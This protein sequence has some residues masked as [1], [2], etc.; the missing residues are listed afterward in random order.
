MFA[1]TPVGLP[2]DLVRR[3]RADVGADDPAGVNPTHTAS[4]S[5]SSGLAEAGP[6]FEVSCTGHE[7][8]FAEIAYWRPLSTLI[9]FAVLR[10]P[11]RTERTAER[12]AECPSPYVYVHSSSLHGTGWLETAD[13]VQRLWNP[14][15]LAVFD[16]TRQG[17]YTAL[18]IS[19]PVG[20]CIPADLLG[21]PD[22]P[23]MASRCTTILDD[24]LA[25]AVAAFVRNFACDAAVRRMDVQVEDELVV[26]D[27]VRAAL[28]NVGG[29]STPKNSSVVRTAAQSV[30]EKCYRD[31]AFGPD[32]IASTLHVSRRQLFRVFADIGATPADLIARRRLRCAEHLLG[33]E[34]RI[35][36]ERVARASGFGS[37][38]TL[39]NRFR[40]VHGMTPDEFRRCDHCD[41]GEMS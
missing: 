16:G 2:D 27:M 6:A 9:T 34:N 8:S 39:R 5:G 24:A 26:V 28:D 33:T 14:G 12:I 40:A 15:S 31:P 19:D 7:N 23:T 21:T 36:L 25:R 32:E 29:S 4:L 18:S 41:A 10:T 37:V 22:Q 11:C 38:A 13:H 1:E 35:S 3:W 17:S 20:V 30:I